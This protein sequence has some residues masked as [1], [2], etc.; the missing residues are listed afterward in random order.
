MGLHVVREAPSVGFH[1]ADRLLVN[2]LRLPSL[3]FEVVQ[4]ALELVPLLVVSDTERLLCLRRGFL[5]FRDGLSR[6]VRLQSPSGLGASFSCREP[7]LGVPQ[8]TSGLGLL[9]DQRSSLS[10]GDRHALLLLSQRLGGLGVVLLDE[11]ARER[12]RDVHRPAHR[13]SHVLGEDADDRLDRRRGDREEQGVLV[14]L[15]L[16]RDRQRVPPLDHPDPLGPGARGGPPDVHPE[17]ERPEAVGIGERVDGQSPLR[18]PRVHEPPRVLA[19][20]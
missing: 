10:F 12:L 2:G 7:L 13:R 3:D 20:L 15:A 5:G 19:P 16:E 17:R 8:F 4:L 11:R 1:V 6:Q 14:L 9:S 18:R